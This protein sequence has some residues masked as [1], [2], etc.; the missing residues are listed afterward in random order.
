MEFTFWDSVHLV[1]TILVVAI[2]FLASKKMLGCILSYQ[3]TNMHS[4]EHK[5]WL[6]I[7]DKHGRELGVYLFRLCLAGSAI[8]F[9]MNLWHIFTFMGEHTP[10][11]KNVSWR[12]G[13]LIIAII[14][15][16]L[17]SEFEHESRKNAIS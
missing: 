7:F 14:C 4:Y 17:A 16:V 5:G 6:E 10:S 8:M 12:A 9:T 13:N 2:Y 3:D 1:L 11:I 15:L